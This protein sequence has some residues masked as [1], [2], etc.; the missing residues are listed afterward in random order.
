M[1]IPADA[2]AGTK[3]VI[4]IV[5]LNVDI[6]DAKD[7]TDSLLLRLPDQQQVSTPPASCAQHAYH[8]PKHHWGDTHSKFAW[9]AKSVIT[10]T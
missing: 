10:C 5:P 6:E 2:I 4:G 3:H 9:E 7:N 8:D 1:R